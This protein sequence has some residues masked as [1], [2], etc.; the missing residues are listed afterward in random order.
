MGRTR[1]IRFNRLPGTSTWADS[2]SDDDD[3]ASIAS[4]AS[5]AGST[6]AAASMSVCTSQRSSKGPVRY[7]CYFAHSCLDFRL[8]EFEALAMMAGASKEEIVWEAPVD[9]DR[10]S[11]FW[12]VTLP[13]KEVARHVASRAVLLRVSHCT[14][15]QTCIY[16][17][18]YALARRVHACTLQH[19]H[20]CACRAS[21]GGACL[22]DD[23]VALGYSV[24]ARVQSQGVSRVWLHLFGGAS[25]RL[26]GSCRVLGIHGW[27]PTTH[28]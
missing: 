8:A 7:L 24:R 5:D 19:T 4:N 20:A 11:P 23:G 6:S 27:L 13:S 2:A 3:A 14:C 21:F 9:G 25:S 10:E 15:I 18:I 12:F 28:G 16:V 17:H 22:D 26:W 1:R